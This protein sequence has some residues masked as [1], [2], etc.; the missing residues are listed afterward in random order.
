MNV[1]SNYNQSSSPNCF[2]NQNCSPETV[3]MI[4]Q[5]KTNLRLRFVWSATF[6][7]RWTFSVFFRAS[8]REDSKPSGARTA[9]SGSGPK[10]S[11][12][13]PWSNA[14][15]FITE[16]FLLLVISQSYNK[17]TVLPRITSMITQDGPGEFLKCNLYFKIFLKA[18]IF[19]TIPLNI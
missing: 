1:A 13:V 4:V 8:R 16:C 7:F 6:V 19:I 17:T 9:E 2:R 10:C 18:Y 11:P 5:W 15:Q 12:P 3:V 14:K